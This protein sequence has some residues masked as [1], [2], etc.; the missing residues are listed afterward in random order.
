MCILNFRPSFLLKKEY[1]LL[2]RVTYYLK[3]PA[4]GSWYAAVIVLDW[5]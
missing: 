3:N 1:Q 4:G 5:L 2:F